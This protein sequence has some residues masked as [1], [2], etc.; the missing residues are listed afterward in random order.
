MNLFV[1][2]QQYQEAFNCPSCLAY[3]NQRWSG[4]YYSQ[5]LRS[6]ESFAVAQCDHC[7]ELSYWLSDSM[8]YPESHEFE[9]P[10][11]DLGESIIKIYNEASVI[12]VKSPRGAAALLR[13]AIQKICVELGGKGKN[14]NEDIKK[15]VSEG[16]SPK[17]QMMLDYVRVIGNNAVHPGLI[18]IDDDYNSVKILSSLLNEIAKEM[19]TKPRELEE[20]YNSLPKEVRESI[21]KRDGKV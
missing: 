17:V 21:N 20:L 15:L 18:S 19:I 7:G 14:L 8:I 2:P 4:A 16:L 3:A 5:L 6:D 9:H 1:S 11:E 13:L 12:A 10:S